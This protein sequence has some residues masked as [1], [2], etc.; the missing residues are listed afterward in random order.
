MRR[1]SRAEILR[2][3]AA[4]ASGGRP[5]VAAAARTPDAARG[6][7]RGGADLIVSV[8]YGSVAALMPFGDANGSVLASAAE[9]LPLV[10][11]T[12]VLA[13]VC[14]NDPMRVIR[15]HLRQIEEAGFAG[16]QNFPTVGAIDGA[17]RANLEQAGLGYEREVDLVRAARELDLLALAQVFDADQA[18]RMVG[19]GA[20]ILVAHLGLPTSSAI[21]A[22][23]PRALDAGVNAIR[24]IAG[25]ARARRP[26][27]LCLCHGGP[28]AEP[29]DAGYVLGRC[30]ELD[31]VF[32]APASD[33]PEPEAAGAER[34]RRLAALALA[35][36]RPAGAV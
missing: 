21:G 34:A 36:D 18:A 3:L 17:F 12:P 30:P 2:A 7:A 13:A 9:M 26:D 23:R 33:R 35:R 1:P 25:A 4:R 31:G 20:D 24:K 29:A 8:A 19:A 6:A 5:I 22:S 16:V 28:I 27:V 32:D 14:G 15:L 11:Q 10:R